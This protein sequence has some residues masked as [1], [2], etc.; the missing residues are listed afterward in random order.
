MTKKVKA[1]ST[2]QFI[3][4]IFLLVL[5]PI[6]VLA[7]QVAVKLFGKAEGTPANIVVNAS[8]NLGPLY[9]FW[10]AFAQGGEEK[11]D[12]LKPVLTELAAL[13]LK[14]VRLD[15]IYDAY[16]VVKKTGDGAIIYDWTQLDAAV[17]SITKVGAIP[18]LSLSYMPTDLTVNDVVGPPRN[19]RDWENLV[20]A[21]V[22]HYSG[23]SAGQKYL[24]NV[25]YE[26]WN[27]PDLFGKWKTY[28]EKNYLDLYGHTSLGAQRAR[29]V[30]PFKIGG[31]VTTGLYHDWI[32]SLLDYVKTNNIRLDFLSYHRYSKDP[33]D[34]S[35]D[36]N[37]LSVWLS[38]YPEYKSLP[39]VISEW[40]SDPGN[41]SWHD[42]VIDAIHFLASARQ[43]AQRVELAFSFEIKDGLSQTNNEYWGR[44]GLLTHE[45][46]GKHKKPKYYSVQFLNNLSGERLE[47]LGEGSWVTGLATQKDNVYQ[48]LL[49]NYDPNGSHSETVP[50][51]IVNL[52]SGNYS[53]KT[54]NFLA[55][56]QQEN[57]TLLT[58]KWQT[59]LYL[60]AESA[61]LL[62]LTKLSSVYK[63]VPGT[64]GNADDLALNL[65]LDSQPWILTRDQFNLGQTG[66]IEF[67]LKL[68]LN[69][70]DNITIF[71]LPQGENQT[72]S[73]Q[74]KP[75][76]FG[77]KLVFGIL[78]KETETTTVSIPVSDWQEKS[79]HEVKLNWDAFGLAIS[80][81]GKTMQNGGAVNLT[82]IGDLTFNNFGG[83]IDELKIND[84]DR[85]IL[86][87]NF[88]GDVIK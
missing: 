4:L 71:S 30:W 79:W 77:S 68:D 78:A 62:T 54:E 43:M 8:S 6:L 59:N 31:P 7:A 87:R 52:P 80:L 60:P 17:S 25:Y 84:G 35:K 63:F 38:S 65:S 53:L 75:S 23:K 74:K 73:L 14:Y 41:S 64:S 48:I 40:G 88:D 81:D 20:T 2:K 50:V 18:L 69:S 29:N 51:S 39:I 11:G 61:V 44:W 26:A 66:N 21:T 82:G 42:G 10:Q 32:V 34:F 15:H 9:P 28:G 5:L 72:F 86:Q 3:L 37:D 36:L 85:I 57:L 45:K 49:V 83:A 16:A 12:M 47:L 70:Q 33:D 13:S 46:F 24:S 1:T 56:T 55:N 67:F 22:E 19:W 76:G 58:G 27:E